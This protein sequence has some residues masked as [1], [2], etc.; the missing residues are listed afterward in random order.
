M[1]A[2]RTAWGASLRL[3]G[4]ARGRGQRKE[5]RRPPAAHG[6]CD[7]S[8]DTPPP[9]R[10]THVRR[11]IANATRAAAVRPAENAERRAALVEQQKCVA[12]Q[13]LSLSMPL[14]PSLSL[15]FAALIDRAALAAERRLA[16]E[17]ASDA[18]AA[19]AALALRAALGGT[20]RACGDVAVV[21]TMPKSAS[22]VGA[23]ARSVQ[24]FEAGELRLVAPRCSHKSRRA[25]QVRG[26]TFT[27]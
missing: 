27:P 25:R 22:N 26:M 1:R 9:E 23:I 19:A 20:P 11:A 3:G 12:L 10:L 21:L 6:G 14:S 15:T 16:Q 13:S 18:D 5:R 17:D 8:R 2:D 24:A 7:A 4:C